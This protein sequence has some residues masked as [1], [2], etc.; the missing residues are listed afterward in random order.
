MK[1]DAATGSGDDGA[2]AAGWAAG[3]PGWPR[4]RGRAWRRMSGRGLA[5]NAATARL[6][7]ADIRVR[8]DSQRFTVA[9]DTPSSR[10]SCSWLRPRRAR[11]PRSR[12]AA[13]EPSGPGSGPF[14]S[15]VSPFPMPIPP[16]PAPFPRDPPGGSPLTR[17]AYG[18]GLGGGS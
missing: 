16:F 5:S 6:A 8:P 9:N 18:A 7:R 14:P 3:R 13:A 1:L 2:A 12:A 4:R 15:A 10:A 11:S 17:A